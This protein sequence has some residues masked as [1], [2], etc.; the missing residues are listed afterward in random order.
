MQLFS[1]SITEVYINLMELFSKSITE[2]HSISLALFF[3]QKKN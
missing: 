1:K 2:V 3:Q